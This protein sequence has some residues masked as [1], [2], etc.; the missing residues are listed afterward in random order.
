MIKRRDMEGISRFDGEAGVAV[1]EES[2]TNG[3]NE[4][5]I[6]VEDGGFGDRE[7]DSLLKRVDAAA[8]KTAMLVKKTKE[9]STVLRATTSQRHTLRSTLQPT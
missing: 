8:S 1:L 5:F 6:V 9:N 2:F 4:V 7:W 3:S